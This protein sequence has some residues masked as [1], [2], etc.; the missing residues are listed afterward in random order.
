M[1]NAFNDLAKVT[2]SHIPATNTPARIYVHHRGR[3]LGS[4]DS[5]PWKMIMAPTSDPSLNP[6]TARSSVP[7][8]EVILDYD[9]V[10][11]ETCWPSKNHEISIHYTALDEI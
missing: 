9:D 6:T 1:P 5:Q 2:R 11:D 8:H 4:K 3:P 7:T 10:S